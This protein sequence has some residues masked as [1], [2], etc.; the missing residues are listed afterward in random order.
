MK[1][2]SKKCPLLITGNAA[3]AV[4]PSLK[5]NHNLALPKAKIIMIV[6]KKNNNKKKLIVWF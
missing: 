4:S 1:E 5:I 2:Y 3:V 6:I